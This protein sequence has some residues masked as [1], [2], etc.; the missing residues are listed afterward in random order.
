MVRYGLAPD[1]LTNTSSQSASVTEHEIP[2]SG[3]EPDTPYYYGVGT[4]SGLI[5][6]GNDDY[7]LVT[8]PLPWSRVPIRI[9][10]RRRA[11]DRAGRRPRS[12]NSD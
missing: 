12:G 1:Q 4:S 5:A 9:V 11:T 8:S 10:R 6:G 2:R 3:L 7:F